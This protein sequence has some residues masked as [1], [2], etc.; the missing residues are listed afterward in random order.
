[1]AS[2]VDT[3]ARLAAEGAP[4]DLGR[5]YVA[6]HSA[7]GHLALWAAGRRDGAVQLA[8]AVAQ[9][10]VSDLVEA[11]RLGLSDNAAALL[12]GGSPEAVPERYAAASPRA[13]LPLG[14]PALLVH[15]DADDAVPVEL[16]RD[17]A[18]CGARGRRRRRVR[19]AGGRRPHGAHR[20]ALGRLGARARLAQGASPGIRASTA[21]GSVKKSR[22]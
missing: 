11:A 22:E 18:V 9:A 3:L 15:G 12:L 19:R 1:M 2:G 16:S 10:A 4:L 17:Y 20:S 21:F 13:R 14:V 8:G 6:G 5:A 7:G